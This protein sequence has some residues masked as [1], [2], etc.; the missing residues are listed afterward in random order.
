MVAGERRLG[1]PG[2]FRHRSAVWCAMRF[3]RVESLMLGDG[4]T[5]LSSGPSTSGRRRMKE[6]CSTSTT[7]L[8]IECARKL[9]LGAA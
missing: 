6:R 3:E 9:L 2:E 1:W 7:D 4:F 5:A 8:R